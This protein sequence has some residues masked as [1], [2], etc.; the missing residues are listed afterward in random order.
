[1]EFLQ[2]YCATE[3]VESRVFSDV[4]ELMESFLVFNVWCM[5]LSDDFSVD[6]FNIMFVFVGDG[7]ML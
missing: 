1:M 2:L 4:K 3:L 7:Y 6:D 5:Y